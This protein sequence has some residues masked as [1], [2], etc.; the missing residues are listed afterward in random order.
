MKY[1]NGR[2]LS[3]SV[4]QAIRYI[5][6]VGILTRS[7][8]NEFFCNGTARWKRKQLRLLVKAKV[9]RPHPFEEIQDCFV[10]GHYGNQLVHEMKWKGVHFTQPQFIKHDE[11]VAKGLITLERNKICQRWLTEAE[12]KIQKSN[13]FKLHNME[14][15]IKYPDAVLKIECK[16]NNLVFALEYEKTLKS[17]WRYNKAIKSY[18]DSNDFNLIVF[19]VESQ[20]IEQSIKRSMRFIADHSLN[21]KIGFIS[22]DDWLKNPL[23][24]PIRDLTKGKTFTEIVQNN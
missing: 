14:G 21:S 5:T 3:P 4:F 24:A 13:T 12:L 23:E 7:T 9:L 15:G 1:A 20:T 8:W 16:K 6:K 11:T 18:S 22:I 17:S 10:L 19:I 2:A